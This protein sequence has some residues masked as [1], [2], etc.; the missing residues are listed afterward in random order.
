MYYHF[1]LDKYSCGK[2]VTLPSDFDFEVSTFVGKSAP[3]DSKLEPTP[4]N[5]SPNLINDQTETWVYVCYDIS[6]KTTS[7]K[8]VNDT[9]ISEKKV[10]D[11]EISPTIPEQ[12]PKDNAFNIL[13]R[14]DN[15]Y[16]PLKVTSTRKNVQQ[17]N[18]I[19]DYLKCG[20]YSVSTGTI[21]DY[22][23]LINSFTDMLWDL[24]CHYPVIKRSYHLPKN[25]EKFLGMNDP[26]SHGHAIPCFQPL[27]FS[28]HIMK[29]YGLL[30]K[31][32]MDKN[33]TKRLKLD[34][35]QTLEAVT[36]YIDYLETQKC[37][38]DTIQETEPVHDGIENFIVSDLKTIVGPDVWHQHFKRASTALYESDYYA[39]INLNDMLEYSS[40][41]QLYKCINHIKTDGFPFKCTYKIKHFRL[42]SAGPHPAIHI[43]WKQP[44][45]DI[46]NNPKELQLI[47]NIRKNSKV[48]VRKS[49]RRE[50]KTKLLRLSIVKPST[51]YLERYERFVI[52]FI[53]I[54]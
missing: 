20:K 44:C 4:P 5:L 33:H 41:E 11:T 31:N 13:M 14:K 39:P 47:E 45:D 35:E 42:T 51:F 46:N 3:A 15:C 49:S 8:E 16:P 27:K 22:T 9:E 38:N 25:F 12:P 17:Y 19:I 32:Y 6:S 28:S 37:R 7:E 53:L 10:N 36:K 34:I 50:I 21:V 30:D 48:F 29:I 23:N 52:F 18:K 43:L 26:K 24:D 40:P 1:C 54:M 2:S